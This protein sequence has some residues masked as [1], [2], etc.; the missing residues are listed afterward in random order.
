MQLRSNNSPCQSGACSLLGIDFTKPRKQA[1]SNWLKG[2][3]WDLDSINAGMMTGSFFHCP[4]QDRSPHCFNGTQRNGHCATET[5]GAS[6]S[7]DS[8]S[9][10]G[11]PHTLE[12]PTLYLPNPAP[13]T[14]LIK[15][16]FHV[17]SDSDPGDTNSC[18]LCYDIAPPYY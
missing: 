17:L 10:Y 14:D 11:K 13:L 4:A 16:T 5:A 7:D 12:S 9:S 1:N 2:K 15:K 3:T 8:V 6:P 18:W